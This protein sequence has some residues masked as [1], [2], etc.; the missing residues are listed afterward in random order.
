MNDYE[1]GFIEGLIDGE[2]CISVTCNKQRTSP[3]MRYKYTLEITNTNLETLE[4]AQKIIGGKITPKQPSGNRKLVYVLRVSHEGIR[5]LFKEMQLIVK[6]KQ[7][8]ITSKVLELLNGPYGMESRGKLK[9]FR[10]EMRKCNRRG[11]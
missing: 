3:N 5:S 4:K 9:E 8:E 1:R 2:G 7:Q 10:E 6:K 11:K